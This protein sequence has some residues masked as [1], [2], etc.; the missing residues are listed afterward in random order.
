MR[1]LVRATSFLGP[2]WP[3]AL[4]A[5]ISLIVVNLVPRFYDPSEGHV[6]VDG[7]DDRDVT[8]DS[9]RCQIGV[10]IMNFDNLFG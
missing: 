9:L 1:S 5:F 10:V 3:T 4:S 2:Y 6:L 8:I 7:F